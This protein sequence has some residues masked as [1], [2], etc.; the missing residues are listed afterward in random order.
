MV[1]ARSD[2]LVAVVDFDNR[3]AADNHNGWVVCNY[4]AK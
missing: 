4:G 1:N 3:L 2:I